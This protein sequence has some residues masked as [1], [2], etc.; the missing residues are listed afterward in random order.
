MVIAVSSQNNAA[1]EGLYGTTTTGFISE[2]TGRKVRP[3]LGGHA[4]ARFTL[5]T[6]EV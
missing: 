4:L 5:G 2:R 6:S 1:T 3:R